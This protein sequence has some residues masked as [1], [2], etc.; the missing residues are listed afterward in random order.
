M[1]KLVLSAFVL[2]IVCVGCGEPAK[3]TTGTAKASSAPATSS[4]AKDTTKK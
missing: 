4:P 2:S 3:P 1:K